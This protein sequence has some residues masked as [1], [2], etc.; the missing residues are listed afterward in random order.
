M[1]TSEKQ[2]IDELFAKV[3]KAED[4]SAPRDIDAESRIREHLDRQPAAPYY[5]AQAI[6]VQEQALAASQAR[7][8]TLETQLSERSSGGGFLGA[9]FGGGTSKAS[10]SP[11][12]P[13]G[14]DPRVSDAMNPHVPRGG[15]GFLAGAMQTALGVAGGV[16]LGN[17]VAHMFAEPAA[18][19]EPPAHDNPPE[20]DSS[21]EDDFSFDDDF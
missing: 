19:D 21:L 7:I 3:R 11:A 2:V 20:D 15:G 5:M 1:D 16:L 9:L 14:I 13:R 8:Q 10:P 17:A 12:A 4:Q 6:L 18:A